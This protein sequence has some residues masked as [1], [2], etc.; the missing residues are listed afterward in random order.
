[1]RRYVLPAALAASLLTTATV[2]ASA[3]A[4]SVQQEV[5]VYVSASQI[6]VGW[7]PSTDFSNEVIAM[8]N[9]YETLLRYNPM[10]GHFIPVLATGYSESPNHLA[11]T[12]HIRHGV[13]F[14]S[15]DLMTAADVKASIE[16]TIQL[17]QGASYIWG[18]VKSIDTPNQWTVVFHLK[19]PAPLN[20]IAASPYGA[21]IFDVRALK[22]HGPNWFA[23]GHED[24]TG[25]YELQSYQGGTLVLKAFPKYWGGWKGN[26][27]QKVIFE[28]VSQDS[29]RAQMVANGEADYVDMLSNS[30]F[31][32]LRHNPNVSVNVG[33]S[34]QNLL[35]FFDTQQK[36][37]T[38]LKVR[39]ALFYTYPAQQV[40]Q[41]VMHGMASVAH[42]PVPA[43]LWG[44]D[45][46]LPAPTVNLALARKLLAE[47][48]YPHGFSTVLTYTAGDENEANAAA[49][50]AAEAAKV[51][52][53]I[54]VEGMPWTAQWS[55]AKSPNPARRQ[56]IFLMYWW[57]D[58]TSPYSFLY[59][60]FHSEQ[61]I[62]FN[63]AY[64]SNPEVDH[65]IDEG[66]LAAGISI[67]KG[68]QDFEKAQQIIMANY[69]V[70][71]M[72]DEK[73]ERAI[74][75][76]LAGYVDNP[77]YPNV[78]FWYDVHWRN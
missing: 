25:P 75:S 18:A 42:G 48:G 11:W 58:Y 68:A 67:A 69:P 70:V 7:D 64:F 14:H 66:N 23:D 29:T 49:L 15:G 22:Q 36:P 8:N 52:V 71:P 20:L 55:L 37:F 65:Y 59:N 41:D 47:A 74:S 19:Y 17:G 53:H 21:F 6:M 51:G 61:T 44:H 40:V 50:W 73:Y 39:E 24:G 27:F 34:F 12:F 32:T 57:P 4:A 45:P 63:M 60:M 13:Y 76:H 10:T 35:A 43:G 31:A 78:V 54:R 38:N 16:R 28:T 9:M 2:S 72:F 5:G 1:M 26:H 3:G 46:K 56:G 33:P 77:S 62:N 30:D